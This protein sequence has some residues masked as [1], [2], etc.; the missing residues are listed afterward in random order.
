NTIGRLQIWQATAGEL[1]RHLE[2]IVALGYRRKAKQ[3]RTIL[4][5]MMQIAVLHNVIPVNPIDGVDSFR[6]NRRTARGKIADMSALPAFRP[7][8][9]MGSR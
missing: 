8:T 9:R 3:H 6:K 2:N 4:R 7:G 5:A 1:D